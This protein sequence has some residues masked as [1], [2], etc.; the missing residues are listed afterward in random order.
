M[1]KTIYIA[2]NCCLVGFIPETEDDD[3]MSLALFSCIDPKAKMKKLTKD[4]AQSSLH[5]SIEDR[6]PKTK[7]YQWKQFDT[8]DQV[9][10]RYEQM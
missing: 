2:P 4:G 5:I 7:S 6:I 1:L 3:I 9:E 10:S 8:I